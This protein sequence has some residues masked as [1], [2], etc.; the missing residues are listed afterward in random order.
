MN[1]A[2]I[3]AT[4]DFEQ[5]PEEAENLI[6]NSHEPKFL[7]ANAVAVKVGAV[8]NFFSAFVTLSVAV[9]VIMRFYNLFLFN[10]NFSATVA[11]AALG[12][13]VLGA[14]CRNGGVNN[15][16]VTERINFPCLGLVATSALKGFNA[17][18]RAGGFG[19]ENPFAA[20]IVTER[21][22]D[23]AFLFLAADRA[24]IG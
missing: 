12:E 2:A 4:S 9:A 21:G 22:N 19:C 18:L 11:M 10:K 13:S 20:P 5:L 3:A 8:L 17:F 6:H 1:R 24:N 7:V 15:N 14:G 23:I 16:V